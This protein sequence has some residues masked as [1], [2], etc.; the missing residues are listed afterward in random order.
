MTLE[1]A[2]MRRRRNEDDQEEEE[3]DD[4]PPDGT[5]SEEEYEFEDDEFVPEEDDDSSAENI[6]KDDLDDFIVEESPPQKKR[7]QRKAAIKSAQKLKQLSK[8]GKKNSKKSD[9]S[10][11]SKDELLSDSPVFMDGL[12]RTLDDSETHQS[13][14]SPYIQRRTGASKEKSNPNNTSST[15]LVDTPQKTVEEESKSYITSMSPAESE[16]DDAQPLCFDD[17]PSVR[18]DGDDTE[19]EATP[20]KSQFPVKALDFCSPEPQM[21]MIV[22]DDDDDATDDGLVV[23]IIAEVVEDSD[24]EEEFNIEEIED[25]QNIEFEEQYEEEDEEDEED[26]ITES[27]NH[28]QDGK[29]DKVIPVQDCKQEQEKEVIPMP[30]SEEV[31]TGAPVKGLEENE[32]VA[33]EEPEAEEIILLQESEEKISVEETTVQ[34]SQEEDVPIEQPKQEEILPTLEE[35]V[36]TKGEKDIPTIDK[37]ASDNE[38]TNTPSGS[39][40]RIKVSDGDEKRSVKTYQET[41]KL[42]N[43]S[44]MTTPEKTKT[45]KKK[46]PDNYYR[47][48]GAVRRGKWTLGAK[49][50]LGSF[51]EVFVGMNTQNG[52]LMAVKRFRMKGAVMKDIR[53]EI[54]LM[55]SLSHK[56]IVRYYGA[57]MDK[58]NLHIFQEWVP[59][60]SVASLLSKFGSFSIEVIRSYISQTL[61]GLSYLH[62]NDIMHRDIKGSN[63]LVNDEGVVKL[64]DFGASK[65]LANLEDNLMMSMTVRGT[66]YFMALEV[67]EEKYSA[68][69][70]I[71]GIGCVAFQMVTTRPPWKDKGFTNPISLFNHIKKQEGPP[72]MKHPEIDSF[73]KRQQTAWHLFVEMV[74]KCFDHDPSKRPTAKELQNDPFFLTVH[75]MED[76]DPKEFRGLFSPENEPKTP[77]SCD[78]LMSPISY[79]NQT[80]ESPI[81]SPQKLS[82]SPSLQRSKSVVQ[83]KTTFSTPPRP[84]RNSERNS[85]SPYKTP[86][87]KGKKTPNRT[88]KQHQS[89]SPDSREWPE[90]ARNQLNKQLQSPDKNAEELSSLMGSLALSEDSYVENTPKKQQS[91]GRRSSSTATSNLIGLNFL[92]NSN[93]TYEI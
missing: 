34:E 9:L 63:I 84:K 8:R 57:Q 30:E 46:R 64:A 43:S 73:S 56:N 42:S 7:P 5:S 70:D 17:S 45:E 21:A 74:R 89:P 18:S 13:Q 40:A 72:D 93:P 12:K 14:S 32:C 92:E 87:S 69:A 27:N 82:N 68:K 86:K 33:P 81:R 77:A 39:A 91:T 85:P 80:N 36:T 52:I 23:T 44:S 75:D 24:N 62:A 26:N 65:K 16:V 29:G 55:R 79:G 22:D 25:D 47:Q 19:V 38:Y 76:E 51:G 58:N 35:K 10:V 61:A 59:G 78:D 50:G 48:E 83:W 41:G 90:W 60:G 28:G 4:D 1:R 37:N 15:M 2:K 88:P 6:T 66:P 53:T 20:A 67:F 3:D 54:E 31:E 49:I 71:W 11:S